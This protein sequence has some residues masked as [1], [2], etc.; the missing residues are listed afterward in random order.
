MPCGP[1][2]PEAL[3]APH[4][5]K[6]RPNANHGRHVIRACIELL[7]VIFPIPSQQSLQHP[8][9]TKHESL[10]NRRQLAHPTY[11]YVCM[12]DG[13]RGGT[14]AKGGVIVPLQAHDPLGRH[15]HH[16]ASALR[17]R[18][19][20]SVETLVS[21]GAPIDPDDAHTPLSRPPCV[22]LHR[23]LWKSTQGEDATT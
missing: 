2:L 21:D 14:R 6:F 11:T 16:L 3:R 19:R 22:F 7:A 12:N 1:T 18:T 5:F 23:T 10:L 9:G 20:H 13:E 17:V 8:F 4:P 15:I